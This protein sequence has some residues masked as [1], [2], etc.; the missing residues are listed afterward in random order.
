MS[1]GMQSLELGIFHNPRSGLSF[2]IIH[3]RYKCHLLQAEPS[4]GEQRNNR[5]PFGNSE[6]DEIERFSLGAI[7]RAFSLRISI[8]RSSVGLIVVSSILNKEENKK[9]KE[10]LVLSVS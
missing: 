8:K 4:L 1:S 10:V 9:P 3:R 7:L 2:R 6:K 5:K